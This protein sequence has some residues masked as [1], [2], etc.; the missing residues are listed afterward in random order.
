M[1]SN[2]VESFQK[3]SSRCSVS[4]FMGNAKEGLPKEMDPLSSSLETFF[5]FVR[6]SVCLSV[7]PFPAFSVASLLLLDSLVKTSR[8]NTHKIPFKVVLAS[9]NAV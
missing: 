1:Q 5:L 7:F 2:L 6:L 8:F 9:H 3:Y 4:M